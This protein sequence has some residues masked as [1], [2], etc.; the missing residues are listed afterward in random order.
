M[1]SQRRRA[2]RT[3]TRRSWCGRYRGLG[4]GL[5]E[6]GFRARRRRR[7]RCRVGALGARRR[8][9][10][11]DPR[12]SRLR[13]HPQLAGSRNRS[14][15]K[16]VNANARR[17]RARRRAACCGDVLRPR[18]GEYIHETW[19]AAR[20]RAM[21]KE[22]RGREDIDGEGEGVKTKERAQIPRS[23]STPPGK[24]GGLWETFGRAGAIWEGAISISTSTSTS[25]TSGGRGARIGV[26]VLFRLSVKRR[27]KQKSGRGEGGGKDGE[28]AC[29]A[30]DVVCVLVETVG[31]CEL[32]VEWVVGVGGVGVRCARGGAGA[33]IDLKLVLAL[34]GRVFRVH[35]Y[36]DIRPGARVGRGGGVPAVRGVPVRVPGQV[37]ARV[38]LRG[39]R[40]GGGRRAQRERGRHPAHRRVCLPALGGRV[41]L[42]ALGV[43][44]PPCARQIGGR[45]ADWPCAREVHVWA[46]AQPRAVGLAV[47]GD[48]W[49]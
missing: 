49:A 24:A 12:R 48:A 23:A 16:N 35:I 37:S 4:I 28:G 27:K 42:P 18:G 29:D 33:E 6:G 13:L 3:R 43:G 15:S 46:G 19:G 10:S 2:R 47:G 32:G 20:G 36:I 41:S 21:V 44:V 17:S 34:E 8:V 40:G 39:R 30:R 45:A 7:R 26:W 9:P 38:L 25:S 31:S 1:T 5:G 14:L 22:K 11:R